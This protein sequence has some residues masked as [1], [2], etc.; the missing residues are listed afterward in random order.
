MENQLVEEYRRT[1]NVELPQ[2]ETM[3]GYLDFILSK[4]R[5]MSE[6][7]REEDFWFGTR[8]MEVRDDLD[9]HEDILH[10]FGEGGEYL[11]SMDGNV[12]AGNWRSIEHPNSIILTFGKK[13]ELY[14]LA[15][16]NDNFFVL[17]K[18]GDQLRKGHKKYFVLGRESVVKDLEW[19]DSMELMFN[20]YRGNARWGTF[21]MIVIVL[22]AVIVLLSLF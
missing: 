15:F 5:P 4:I 19:R 10:I 11:V 14:D 16:L 8:W 18:H 12:S 1:F 21:V 3:D 9:F 13:S 20:I 2:Q 22:L 17:R 7:L 6:D